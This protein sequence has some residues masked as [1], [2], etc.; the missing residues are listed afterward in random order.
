MWRLQVRQSKQDRQQRLVNLVRERS[1]GSQQEIVLVMA[2]S[3]LQVTQTCI[4]RDIR[5]LGLVKIG[6]RYAPPER[7][8]VLDGDN[9]PPD[10]VFALVNNVDPVGAN[11]IV[12]RTG[13][14][15]AN[16]VAA[17][18]DAKGL[19]EAAGT[20][21]GDDTIFIAVRSRSAQ[22]RLLARLRGWMSAA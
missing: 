11:L 16:S 9:R 21:A 7:V 14:G 20:L 18:L 17:A 15:C 1:V 6:G 4:S 2:E 5:E 3:G 19:S 13:T 10:P 8:T 22:G 12:V